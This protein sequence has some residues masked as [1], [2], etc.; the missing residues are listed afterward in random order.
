M[1]NLTCNSLLLFI[2]LK[3]ESIDINEFQDY[4]SSTDAQSYLPMG[5]K[6]Q[7][8][9]LAELED[10]NYILLD[11]SGSQWRYKITESAESTLKADLDI[12]G[13]NSNNFPSSHE[14]ELLVANS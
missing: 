11:K 9:A 7:Q 1:T 12:Y 13:Q 3:D 6:D 5:F 2:W 14:E 8:V 10:N 4:P